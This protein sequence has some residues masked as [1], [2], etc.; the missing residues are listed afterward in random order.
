MK[1]LFLLMLLPL[2]MSVVSCEKDDNSSDTNNSQ[3]VS[4]TSSADVQSYHSVVLKG[5]ANGAN[6]KVGF[7]YST[8]D[9]DPNPE[10]CPYVEISSVQADNSYELT[11]DNLQPNTKY[12]YRAFATKGSKKVLANE[13]KTFITNDYKLELMNADDV[14]YNSVVL[15]GKAEDNEFEVG[16]C[17]SDT[18]DTPT[19]ENADVYSAE[20]QSDNFFS[21]VVSGLKQTTTYYY[22]AIARKGDI[23]LLS[24]N[25][26]K[27]TTEEFKLEAVD[28]GLPSGL[29]WANC[30]VGASAPEEY[31][32]YFAWGDPEPYYTEGHSQDETCSNWKDGK[33]GYDWSHY[34]WCDGTERYLLTKYNTQSYG[35]IFDNKAILD[36]ADDAATVNWGGSWRMP[37]EAEQEELCTNCTWTRTTLNGVNGYKVVGPNGKSIFL[38]AAG[39]RFVDSLNEA[40]SYASYWSSSLRSSNC[41]IA[42]ALFI[43]SD[44]YG[45]SGTGR[46]AGQ[47]VR[48]VC[49]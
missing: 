46:F 9:K 36:D 29:K 49:E 24:K 40:G 48:P 2:V 41:Y 37:T 33:S 44:D 4:I 8:T 13:V 22:R 1:K 45:C 47:P 15:K 21:V 16:F 5:Y 18:V 23:I 14:T 11:V 19:L 25:I 20:L 38:P 43:S 10:S 26:K 35:G 30:N 31:G 32:D 6:G 39:Y 27:I 12:Y 42:C 28:L 34:K 3:D 17:I 7:C